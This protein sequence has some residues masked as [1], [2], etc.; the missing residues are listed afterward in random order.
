MINLLVATFLGMSNHSTLMDVTNRFGT[1]ISI[2]FTNNENE[3]EF[4]FNRQNY[5]LTVFCDKKSNVKR[6]ETYGTN[7]YIA[8]NGVK[9]TDDFSSVM[10]KMG[11]PKSYLIEDDYVTLEYENSAFTLKKYPKYKVVGISVNLLD[12]KQINEV[13]Q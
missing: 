11:N 6:I 8:Y 9:L 13:K 2:E 3:N 5:I 10:N 1:P 12:K 7:S 4:K